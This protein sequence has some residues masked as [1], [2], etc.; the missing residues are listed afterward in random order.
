MK[1]L[2]NNQKRGG[3]GFDIKPMLN[4]ERNKGYRCR[5]IKKD[6]D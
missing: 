2:N 4:D 5:R 3:Y 1:P 6:T